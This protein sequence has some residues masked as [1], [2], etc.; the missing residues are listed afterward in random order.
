MISLGLGYALYLFPRPRRLSCVNIK[1]AFPEKKDR[2]IRRIAMSSMQNVCQTILELFWFSGRQERLLKII[3]NPLLCADLTKRSMPKGSLM[4]ISPHIGNWEL[5][6]FSVSHATKIPFAVVARPQNNPRLEKLMVK[7][8]S[9]GG[10]RIIFEKGAVKGIIKALK[11]GC[12][13]ATLIDQNARVRDGG[14]FVDFFGLPAPTSRAPAF[15]AKK[16]NV[17]LAL[18]GCLRTKNGYKMFAEELPKKI[19]DYLSDEEL[20]QDIMKMTESI[21]KKYPEQYLWLY[22]R[23]QHI[24]KD[25]RPEIEKKFPYYATKT[26]PRFYDRNATR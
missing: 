13:L 9:S 6:A 2:E 16:M 11:D 3:E 14:V 10:N 26:G 8:R 21:V 5:A 22:K 15:F 1:I 20:I 24:P 19:P 4:W 12:F 17:N 23:W 18:G 7:L 25:I